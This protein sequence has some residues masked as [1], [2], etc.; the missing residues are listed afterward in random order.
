MSWVCGIHFKRESPLLFLTQR[1]E[2]EPVRRCMQPNEGCFQGGVGLSDILCSSR[3]TITSTAGRS[4]C[5]VVVGCNNSSSDLMSME[6]WIVDR[7]RHRRQGP[8]RITTPAVPKQKRGKKEKKNEM[9]RMQ[10]RRSHHPP[11]GKTLRKGSSFLRRGP[12]C[13]VSSTRWGRCASTI[14]GRAHRG[15]IVM[16]AGVINGGGGWGNRWWG[17]FFFLPARPLTHAGVN[18]PTGLVQTRE[19]IMPPPQDPEWEF[20]KLRTTF[21]FQVGM[22]CCHCLVASNPQYIR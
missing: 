4:K 10:G 1:A 19:G 8:L 7:H 14:P 2:V 17:L 9:R 5:V 3:K 18:E 11:F 21:G 6:G 22:L 20:P 12:F 15:Q 13:Q 16:S